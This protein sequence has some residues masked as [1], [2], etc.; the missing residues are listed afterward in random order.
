M[1]KFSVIL[2]SYAEADNLQSLLPRLM[3]IAKE[4][5]ISYEIIVVDKH[6]STDQSQSLCERLGVRYINRHPTNCYGDAVKTGLKEAR[7]RYLIFMD[8]DGSHPPEFIPT[9]IKDIDHYDLLIASRYIPGGFTENNIALVWM[10]KILNLVYSKLLNIPCHDISNS[11]R[12]YRQEQL[13]CLS[14]YCHHFDIIQEILF[15]MIYTYPQLRIKE[16]PFTFRKRLYGESKRSMVVFILSYF[17]TLIKLFLIYRIAKQSI[18]KRLPFIKYFYREQN[19][20][21]T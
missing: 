13:S 5:L 18:I 6:A 3:T 2:P 19:K 16:V 17:K 8:S 12:V 10:S 15:S 14:F 11:F 4:H 20:D 1:L 21:Q 7:G 9:L